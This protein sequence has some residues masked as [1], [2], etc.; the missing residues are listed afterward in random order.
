MRFL[1]SILIAST[2]LVACSTKPKQRVKPSFVLPQD[3]FIMLLTDLH[4]AES[5]YLKSHDKPKAKK[6]EL[7]T[8]TKHV[9]DKYNISRAYF[10]S[11]LYY[12]NTMPE[13]MLVIYDSILSQLESRLEDL[14]SKAQNKP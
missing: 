6:L 7:Q 8:N 5:I 4:I 3:S 14:D 9:L 11:S 1:L 2:F 13:E 10:D 12:Y